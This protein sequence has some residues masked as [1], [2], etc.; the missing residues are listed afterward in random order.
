MIWENKNPPIA[1]VYW[2]G[3]CPAPTGRERKDPF[4]FLAALI[5][6]LTMRVGGRELM[7]ACGFVRLY[8]DDVEGRGCLRPSAITCGLELAALICQWIRPIAVFCAYAIP[9]HSS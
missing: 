5:Y 9:W 1:G 8:S 4:S 7:T 3:V 6:Y 2:G